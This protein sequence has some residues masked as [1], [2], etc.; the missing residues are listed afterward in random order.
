MSAA[1][2][3]F[4]DIHCHLVS[5]IDDGAKSPEESLAMARLAVREGISQIVATPHQLGNYSCN[6]GA[7]IRRRVAELQAWFDAEAIPLK[8]LPGADV[9]IE[10]GL[11]RM[12]KS[13]EVL[14]LGDHGKHVL[15][16]LP[17]ELYIPL[18]P[19]LA[20]LKT[21]GIVGILSHPERN[22]GIIAR[23]SVIEGLVDQGCLMQVTTGSLLGTFGPL[24]Q[25]VAEQL[26]SKGLVHFLATDAHGSR[27][28]RPLMRQA[29]QRAV[30]LASEEVAQKVCSTF[31]AAV[32][33]GKVVPAG[34]LEAP[35]SRAWLPWLNRKRAA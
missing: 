26:L 23:P 13:G 33:A 28:R 35:K 1:Q 31:P 15:L 27:N 3:E 8:V 22:Q 30:E 14:T 25:K 6:T 12:L 20:Q 17:H 5:G 24:C 18:E 16:E 32:A 11:A 9:R 7:E 10:P 4:V 29:Y 21:V 34:R 2:L 19:L